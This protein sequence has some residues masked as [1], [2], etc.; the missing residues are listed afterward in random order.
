[1][2]SVFAGASAAAAETD[3]HLIKPCKRASHNPAP[4]FAAPKNRPHRTTV[5][6]ARDQSIWFPKLKGSIGN[7]AAKDAFACAQRLEIAANN[8]DLTAASEAAVVLE[9]ELALLAKE[10]RTLIVSS[11]AA[12][13]KG[14]R[15]GRRSN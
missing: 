2:L 3:S 1:M 5:H 7:L 11:S 6:Y 14:H 10:L 4:R 8:G 15:R 13:E 9:S 12:T